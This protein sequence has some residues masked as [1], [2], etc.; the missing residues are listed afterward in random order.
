MPHFYARPSHSDA[1]LDRGGIEMVVC[2][3]CAVVL[4]C[5]VVVPRV[6]EAQQQEQQPRQQQRTCESG[7]PSNIDAGILA[8][9]MLSLLR[10]SETFRAQCDRLAA[11]SRVRVKLDVASML[12]S[13][14]AQTAIHRFTSGALRAEVQLL[15]GQNYRELLAHEFEHIIEQADGVNLRMEAESGRAWLLPGGAY[16]TRRAFA[17]GV[18]VLHEVGELHAHAAALPATR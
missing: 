11:D 6:I 18:Q 12:D 15:F 16:E 3:W 4:L 1:T 7:I 5:V 8:A 2:R 10:R 14:R 17:T 9:D 13:G